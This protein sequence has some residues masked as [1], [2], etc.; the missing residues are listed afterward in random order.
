[1]SVTI[2]IKAYNEEEHIAS[3]IES[4]LRAARTVGGSVLLADSASSDRTVEIAMAYPLR[5]LQMTQGDRR[6]CGAAAQLVFQG[7]Q[8]QYFYLMDG[9]MRLSETFLSEAVAWLD[10]H[11]LCAGVG[12]SVVETLL[13]NSEFKIRNKAMRHEQHRQ[14]GYVDRLDGGGLYRTSAIQ[15]VGYFAHPEL[16]SYE[17]F[18]LAARLTASGWKLARLPDKAVEHT[19]HKKSGFTMLRYR[20]LSGQMGGAGGVLRAALGKPHLGVVLRQ[21]RQLWVYLAVIAW[22]VA[23]PATLLL[24]GPL[25]ALGLLLGPLAFLT[26]RRRSLPLGAY[27]FVYWNL[28]ALASLAA[29]GKKQREPRPVAFRDLSPQTTAP[30][31]P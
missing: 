23:L 13:A 30:A 5:I 9:D 18:D 7:V 29:L 2:A 26:V 3:A 1:M 10:E 31:S 14:A 25:P 4:A 6:S 19:G 12:G 20:F 27:S 15:E 28:C 24:A 16:K 17:E 22:W 11:P 21:L 8:T